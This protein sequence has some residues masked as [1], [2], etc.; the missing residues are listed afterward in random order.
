MLEKDIEKKVCK[1]AKGLGFLVY[2]FSSPGKRAVPDRL[3]ISP[4]GVVFF[5]EFKAWGKEPT[6][7]QALEIRK[8]NGQ[9]AKCLVCD[10]VESGKW[11]IDAFNT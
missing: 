2:K 1:Y 3:F 5:I 10:S 8:I 4:K 9:G 11:A 6:K 7:L